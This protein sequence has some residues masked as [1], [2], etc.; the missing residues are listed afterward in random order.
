MFQ[1]IILHS[2]WFGDPIKCFECE[3]SRYIYLKEIIEDFKSMEPP[4][5]ILVNNAD[6][7]RLLSQ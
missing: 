6:Y 1:L 7:I 2:E 4:I 3:K 5:L